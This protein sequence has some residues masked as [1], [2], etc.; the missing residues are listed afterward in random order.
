MHEHCKIWADL[1]ECKQT[2][3]A[4]NMKKYCPKACGTCGGEKE[5]AA[6]TTDNTDTDG[7]DCEDSH[8]KCGFWAESGE[9]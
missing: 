4:A 9:W 1:G 5:R 7:S 3:S 8:S 2:W 6:K